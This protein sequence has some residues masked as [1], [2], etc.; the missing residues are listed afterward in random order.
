M[1]ITG[2]R[3]LFLE[4]HCNF[5]WRW[6]EGEM[7]SERCP[8][9]SSFLWELKHGCKAT[10]LPCQNQAPSTSLSP[11][12]WYPSEEDRKRIESTACPRQWFWRGTWQSEMLPQ[13]SA[14][15]L[16]NA[17]LSLRFVILCVRIYSPSDNESITVFHWIQDHQI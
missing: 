3:L 14:C 13:I 16:C 8:Y 5:Y 12:E 4:R 7:A 15:N 6:S 9:L 10:L 11:M 17:V 1:I 2:L